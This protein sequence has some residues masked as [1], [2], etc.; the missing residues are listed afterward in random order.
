[1]AHR[2]CLLGR[3]PCSDM[4]R[5][6][7]FRLWRHWGRLADTGRCSDRRLWLP[8]RPEKLLRLRLSDPIRWSSTDNRQ[9]TATL[10]SEG[11]R[12]RRLKWRRSGMRESGWNSLR[13]ACLDRSPGEPGYWKP[14][15][16]SAYLLQSIKETNNFYPHY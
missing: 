7:D 11:R 13:E 1:M 5:R 9:M 3:Y 8:S 2:R 14:S 16:R 15:R 12:I 6:C 10:R 4:P